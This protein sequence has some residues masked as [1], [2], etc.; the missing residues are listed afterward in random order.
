M[1]TVLWNAIELDDNKPKERRPGKLSKAKRSLLESEYSGSSKSP[2]SIVPVVLPP[3]IC[4]RGKG[5][6][7]MRGLIEGASSARE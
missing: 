6:T 5:A 2:A 3:I 4:K 7:M 1:R